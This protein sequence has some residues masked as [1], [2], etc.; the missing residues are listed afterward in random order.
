MYDH[1]RFYSY[2]IITA[3]P[4]PQ[5]P[6]HQSHSAT[7]A[8]WWL[9]QLPSPHVYPAAMAT[10]LTELSDY[11]SYLVAMAT[12]SPQSPGY[13]GSSATTAS[14]AP[15]YHGYPTTPTWLA[16]LLHC[17]ACVLLVR[18]RQTLFSGSS[19]LGVRG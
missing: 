7:R 18:R 14:Q 19:V 13:H 11:Y 8:T 9:L 15:R 2:P 10:L 1:F 16:Q 12:R 3:T 6:R 17:D 4:I 5:L